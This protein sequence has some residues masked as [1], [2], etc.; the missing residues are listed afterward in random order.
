MKLIH[1]PTKSYKL[2][3]NVHIHPIHFCVSCTYFLCGVSI[4]RMKGT[5]KRIYTVGL[6]P[7][8]IVLS[9]IVICTFSPGSWTRSHYCTFIQCRLF[10]SFFC[11][12]VT[13]TG[14]KHL[15]CEG[16]NASVFMVHM[17]LQR[18]WSVSHVDKRTDKNGPYEGSWRKVHTPQVLCGDI[19]Y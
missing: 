19:S 1:S 18:K 17:C 9:G 13:H 6:G 12:T 2:V 14:W 15:K 11:I 10:F 8:L 16:T 3:I 5:H 7:G 4:G